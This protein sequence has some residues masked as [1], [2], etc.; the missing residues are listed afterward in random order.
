MAY[1][2]SLSTRATL[3]ARRCH[4]S[5][6]Y[7]LHDDD[8]KHSS[9]DEDLSSQ[10]VDNFLQRRSFG[11]NSSN[12]S[13]GFGALFPDRGCSH[14]FLPPSTGP[15]FSRYMS[16]TVGEGSDKIE[17]ISDVAG[18]LTDTTVQAVASQVAAV[19][20]VAIAAADSYLPVKALQYFI[21]GVHSFTGLNWWASIA[22]ATLLIRGATAPLL[23]NQLKATTKLTLMRPRL[24][25]LKQQMQDK[26]MDPAAVAEGQ[27]KMQNLFKE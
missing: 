21:D 6:G 1:M 22:L 14:M 18:V 5:F 23:I 20:E 15:S 16:T 7:V 9:T 3:I 12:K 25:E 19:N 11:S 17:M 2:R 4:P 27:R 10:R 8:R 26:G 13:A 24:E